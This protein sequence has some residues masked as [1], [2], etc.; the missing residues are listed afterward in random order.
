M[1]RFHIPP[2][3]GHRPFHWTREE[4]SKLAELGLFQDRRVQLIDGEIVEMSPQRRPHSMTIQLVCEA[5]GKAF[6]QGFSILSQLPLTLGHHSEPEPDVAVVRGSPRDHTEHP[7]TALLVVEVSDTTLEFDS[8]RKAAIYARAG[9]TEYW[10]VN[11]VDNRLEVHRQPVVDSKFE[12]G[13]GYLEIRPCRRD[14][15]VTP[16]AAPLS[17]IRVSDLLP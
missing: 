11:L 7:S 6:G 4:Y 2:Q 5:L 3:T 9:I 13:A 10:I 8:T 14:D 17:K 15:T 12:F 1:I 16:L